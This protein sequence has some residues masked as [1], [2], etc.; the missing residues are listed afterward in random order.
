MVDS[1]GG[2]NKNKR[3]ISS[4]KGMRTSLM[5]S[6]ILPATSPDANSSS[7]STIL[8]TKISST[9]P[10]SY[11]A[12]GSG[13]MV[14]SIS[15]VIETTVDK[16]NEPTTE[17]DS[18]FGLSMPLFIII[19][20]GGFLTLISIVIVIVFV[21]KGSKKKK[22][23]KVAWTVAELA[24]ESPNEEENE[25]KPSREESKATEDSKSVHV[26][27]SSDVKYMSLHTGKSPSAFK[28]KKSSVSK[29]AISVKKGEISL[30]PLIDHHKT[31][32]QTNNLSLPQLIS[33][34]QPSTHPG[35]FSSVK[36]PISKFVGKSP[37]SKFAGKS[38]SSKLA[39]ITTVK[40]SSPTSNYRAESVIG[41]SVMSSAKKRGKLDAE[42]NYGSKLHPSVSAKKGNTSS[43][44][45]G[46]K[47]S[48]VI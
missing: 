14:H 48:S 35:K 20:A 47:T 23:K 24:P 45:K 41:K 36:S 13:S 2:K 15:E 25:N 37:S 5:E 43:I 18:L 22:E 21:V 46:G 29:Q 1:R 11:S 34:A 31:Q 7:F 16:A 28:A 8:F 17:D 10:T 4:T 26:K 39:K 40:T 38:Q 27:Q 3:S 6:S 12:T 42:S 30:P 19:A 44:K 9:S 32:I 33:H